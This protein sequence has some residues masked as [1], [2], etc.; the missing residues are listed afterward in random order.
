M[1]LTSPFG[2][3]RIPTLTSPQVPR[4]RVDPPRKEATEEVEEKAVVAKR[5]TEPAR[6][7]AEA[8]QAPERQREVPAEAG[9]AQREREVDPPVETGAVAREAEVAEGMTA[10]NDYPVRQVSPP[11]PVVGRHS[12]FKKVWGRV[13]SDKCVLETIS[14]GY[15]LEFTRPPPS[16]RVFQRTS[17]PKDPFKKEA[18]LSEVQALLQKG[19]IEW[20]SPGEVSF[21]STFFLP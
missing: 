15:Q 3:H 6:T 5:N 14:S 11:P 17:L 13:T 9:E 18:L 20:V 10:P 7:V 4:S 21:M 8:E 12:L 2:L 16:T 1:G 19:A